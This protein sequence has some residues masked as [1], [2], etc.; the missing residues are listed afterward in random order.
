MTLWHHL[1]ACASLHG[2]RSFSMFACSFVV[3]R[4]KVD[5]ACLIT[6]R[7]ADVKLTNN[8]RMMIVSI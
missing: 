6:G 1:H 7:F 3:C 4:S 2:N 8:Q 5:F